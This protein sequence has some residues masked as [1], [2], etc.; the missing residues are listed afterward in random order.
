MVPMALHFRDKDI[1]WDSVKCFAQVH[2]NGVN[3]SSPIHQ[4]CNPTVEGHHIC[5]A[6]SVLSEVKLA[7][8]NHLLIFHVP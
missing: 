4:S 5:Q 6:Q 8:T 3:C 7:V 2:V 1:I